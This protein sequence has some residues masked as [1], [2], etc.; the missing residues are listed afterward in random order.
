M[1]SPR[2]YN[3]RVEAKNILSLFSS[4]SKNDQIILLGELQEAQSKNT[5]GDNIMQIG[6]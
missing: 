6:V 1:S 3:D 2:N 5:G 4:L